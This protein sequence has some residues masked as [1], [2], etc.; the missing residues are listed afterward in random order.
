MRELCHLVVWVSFFVGSQV[1]RILD[2]GMLSFFAFQSVN[3]NIWPT[4]RPPRN[5]MGI[6]RPFWLVQCGPPF[7]AGALLEQVPFC[8]AGRFGSWCIKRKICILFCNSPFCL[9]EHFWDAKVEMYWF[10]QV[11]DLLFFGGAVKGAGRISLEM[12]L[13]QGLNLVVFW[14]SRMD[15]SSIW[16]ADI[17]GHV[18]GWTRKLYAT[19]QR[20]WCSC[21]SFGHC[22]VLYGLKGYMW[23]QTDSSIQFSMAET[24][25]W[26]L[27]ASPFFVNRKAVASIRDPKWLVPIFTLSPGPS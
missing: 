20:S 12:V 25:S 2:F 6:R 18:C 10:H 16:W 26:K 24:S 21:V 8:Q 11:P 27:R 23:I 14:I 4:S 1:Q 13:N 19:N 5:S 17:R 7:F 3:K 15:G 9:A 22:P